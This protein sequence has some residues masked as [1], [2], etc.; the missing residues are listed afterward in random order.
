MGER[1]PLRALSQWVLRMF[2]K[3]PLIGELPNSQRSSVVAAAK[4][5]VFS[6]AFSTVP[7]WFFPIFSALF[8]STNTALSD[9]IYAS[10]AQG[11]LYIYASSLVGPLV[12]AI[13]FNYATWEP[14]SSSPSA[15]RIGNLTFSFPYGTWFFIISLLICTLAG[16]CFGLM[17]FA[18]TGVISAKLNDHNL[19]WFSVIIYVFS[20]ICLFCVSVYR[21][22]LANGKF[23]EANTARDFFEE[24]TGRNG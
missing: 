13:T 14:K 17:R 7:I 21:N 23:T 8:F 16:M 19:F 6:T 2:R 24:W 12:F 4:E 22:E 1:A 10:I 5:T 15:S 11:D 20:L 9:N 3:L 18:T